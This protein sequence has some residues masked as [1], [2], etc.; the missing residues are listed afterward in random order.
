VA[1][2]VNPARKDIIIDRA[3]PPIEP[4]KQ[5]G[6][7]IGEKFELNGPPRFRL[8]D[9]CARSDLPAADDIANF[10]AHEVA[11][12]ELAIN[13]KVEQRPIPQATALIEVEPDLPYLLGLQGPFRTDSAPCIPDRALGGRIHGFRHFHD[14]SPMARIGHLKNGCS[15]TE[16]VL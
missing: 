8:H 14:D 7:G 1:I 12:A 11:T 10:H 9:D 15:L 13:R 4:G 5:A 16:E 3:A 2:V 6:P